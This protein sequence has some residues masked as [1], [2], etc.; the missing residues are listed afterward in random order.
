MK[1]YA[2]TDSRP[3]YMVWPVSYSSRSL[4]A[5]ST[6]TCSE[7]NDGDAEWDVLF[8]NTSLEGS[9]ALEQLYLAGKDEAYP[10]EDM[11]KW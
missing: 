6:S 3:Q 11:D 8:A 2:T 1:A 4:N 7:Q 9:E 5:R 10:L